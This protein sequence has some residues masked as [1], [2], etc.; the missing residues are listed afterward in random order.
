M[1]AEEDLARRVHDVEAHLSVNREEQLLTD[2][3]FSTSLESA[4]T[5]LEEGE[6][7]LREL[8][9]APRDV[10]LVH[11]PAH[12]FVGECTCGRGG[13]RQDEQPGREPVKPVH[14]CKRRRSAGPGSRTKWWARTVDGVLALIAED[15]DHR[16]LEEPPG[17][18]NGLR[19]AKNEYLACEREVRTDGRCCQACQQR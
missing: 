4:H 3:L 13:C 9:D 15:L 17:G 18:M 19:K 6:A 1:E 12:K 10:L 8:A 16:V 11:F 7:S 2:D 14:R 5:R